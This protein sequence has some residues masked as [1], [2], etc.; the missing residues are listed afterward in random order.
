MKN[1][2]IRFLRILITS[3]FIGGTPVLAQDSIQDDNNG[4]I[5]R[6]SE[7]EVHSEYLEE[8]LNYA[9][10]VAKDSVEKEKDVIS[11]YPMM[12]IKDNNKIR[13]LEI[14]R[15]EEAYKN[16]IASLHFK[17]YKEGTMHM[18]KNLD[19]VDTYQL[20]PENFNKIFK[21]AK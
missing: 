2:T 3:I 6:I 4:M 19:L 12:V 21:K 20:C 16:H 11:I 5:I 9:K 15:N 7:V 17:K 18:V 1:I 13:I 10:E 14:Y 8:Y